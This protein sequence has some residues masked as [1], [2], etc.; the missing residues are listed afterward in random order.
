MFEIKD[1]SGVVLVSLEANSLVK[2]NLSN[3]DLGWADL[4]GADL[5]GANLRGADLRNAD[6]RFATLR[7]AK[8]DGAQLNSANFFGA[9]LS[10][11]RLTKTTAEFANFELAKLSNTSFQSANLSHAR[12]GEATLRETNFASAEMRGCVLPDKL[13]NTNFMFANL[14]DA[15]IHNCDLSK[16]NINDAKINQVRFDRRTK[17][18]S[19]LTPLQTVPWWVYFLGAVAGFFASIPICNFL[20]D[21]IADWALLAFPVGVAIGA[22][23]AGIG[24]VSVYLIRPPWPDSYKFG[25]AFTDIEAHLQQIIPNLPYDVESSDSMKLRDAYKN[26]TKPDN[27]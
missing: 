11:A 24:Q 14:F 18:K 12:F 21:A 19:P 26:M 17:W 2:Q 5:T 9:D 8:L 15:C 3:Y 16:T 20:H 4:S 6:F 7:G 25:I 27:D 1:E 22:L 13:V 10:E 23:L